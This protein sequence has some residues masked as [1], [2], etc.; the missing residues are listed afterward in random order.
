MLRGL[1]VLRGLQVSKGP[2]AGL[3]LVSYRGP[4]AGTRLQHERG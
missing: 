3:E 2:A 4:K 1:G